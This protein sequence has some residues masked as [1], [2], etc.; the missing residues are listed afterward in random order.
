MRET[1]F[2]W[3]GQDLT[4]SRCLDLFAGSGALG[5]EA[6]S[7]GASAVVMIEHSRA[8]AEALRANAALLGAD[9]A[10]I[11]TTDALH[12][13]ADADAGRFDVIFVDPPYGSALAA[14]VLP[15]LGDRLQT[16]GVVYVESAA[17]IVPG[18][19]WRVVREGRAGAVHYHLLQRCGDDDQGG[20]SGDV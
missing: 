4:G 17:T 11:V 10:R 7:R 18:G 6:L 5:F 2:N 1:L 14:R 3:L 13:V 12:F 16:H 19:G 20:V 15:R 9:A 8:A